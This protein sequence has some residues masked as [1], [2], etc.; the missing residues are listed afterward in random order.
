[1]DDVLEFSEIEN[2]Q[3]QAAE[4]HEDLE[5]KEQPQEQQVKTT[6]AS[7]AASANL[8]FATTFS[9]NLP[10]LSAAESA[11]PFIRYLKT[12]IEENSDL[13]IAVIEKTLLKVIE[14]NLDSSI[15]QD[16]RKIKLGDVISFEKIKN[17][18]KIGI[19]DQEIAISSI[20]QDV[21]EEKKLQFDDQEYVQTI[22]KGSIESKTMQFL[23]LLT[24]QLEQFLLLSIEQERKRLLEERQQKKMK[25]QEESRSKS[26]HTQNHAQKLGNKIERFSQNQFEFFFNEIEKCGEDIG[27]NAKEISLVE[28]FSKY[29]IVTKRQI[30]EITLEEVLII[31]SL[32]FPQD[33][34]YKPSKI[35]NG[36]ALVFSCSKGLQ[37]F[38]VNDKTYSPAKQKYI[39]TALTGF[40]KNLD[41]ILPPEKLA[42]ILQSTDGQEV[43]DDK[44]KM[45]MDELAG[46]NQSQFFVDLKE[47]IYKSLGEGK[48]LIRENGYD[49]TAVVLNDEE[50]SISITEIRN[51]WAQESK[52]SLSDDEFI[53]EI[54]PQHDD[55]D[56]LNSDTYKKSTE[57][58]DIAKAIISMMDFFEIDFQDGKFSSNFMEVQ[59][60]GA[61]AAAQ[62]Y[63]ARARVA[64]ATADDPFTAAL[65]KMEKLAREEEESEH[66]NKRVRGGAAAYDGSDS[67]DNEKGVMYVRSASAKSL[68]G[69]QRGGGRGDYK[70]AA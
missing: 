48:K 10:S 57:L 40:S 35:G 59:N 18:V 23:H 70:P 1:M 68:Q 2:K 5:Q 33:I 9:Q 4:Q 22:P 39:E 49:K 3:G 27:S 46:E 36:C 63:E 26:I 41:F 12:R 21:G 25:M 38:N 55:S 19:A 65:A 30:D 28:D 7:A 67:D 14:S 62:D 64:L 16:E 6:S 42:E 53:L 47:A 60:S 15:E 50:N 54:N 69:P 24:D 11:I 29:S 52:I 43:L 61:G 56:Y 34:D 37:V 20:V 44:T 32:N 45:L 58:K 8:G 31:E 17:F 13:Q 66:E 51:N